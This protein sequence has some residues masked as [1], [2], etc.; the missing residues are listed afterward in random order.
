ML[1]TEIIKVDAE[2]TKVNISYC[3]PLWQRD[4]QIKRN[5]VKYPNR[6]Q[7]NYELN[8][9]P[10][11]V[12]C[13]G[14]SLNETWESIKKYKYIIS[15]SGSHKFL[16]EKGIVPTWHV[17]VDPRPH[18]IE[19][20]GEDIHPD[21]EF[22][23]SSCCHPK[24]LNHLE[25]HKAK[26]TLWHTYC[27]ENEYQVPLVFPK[28]EWVLT[29]GVNAGLRALVI[30]RFLGF[31]NIHVFGMDGN[32]PKPEENNLRHA[33][34]HPNVSKEYIIATLDGI[35]YYTTIGF[36]AA[37]RQ[38]FH[39]ISLLSDIKVL[40]Y[41]VGLVQHM[42]Y[43]RIKFKK[44]REEFSN[45][46][47]FCAPLTI[48]S[49]S[50]EENK[51][52]HEE[53]INYGT[54]GVKYI[55]E[56]LSLYS[57]IEAKSLLDYGCG[58]GVLSNY[59]PF[60]IWEYDPAI[61]GKNKPPRSAELVVNI[62]VLEH[63]EPDYLDATLMDLFR[64]TLKLCF[65]VIDLEPSKKNLSDGRNAHINQQTKEWWVEKLNKYFSVLSEELSQDPQ[66]TLKIKLIPRRTIPVIK[67]SSLLQTIE[68]LGRIEKAVEIGVRGGNNALAIL[69][70]KV[71]KL[72]LVDPYEPYKDEEEWL[73]QIKQDKYKKEML[74]KIEP[75]KSK[76]ETIFLSSKGASSFFKEKEL[77][78]V[79]I[80]ANHSYENVKEDIELWYP[81]VKLG[82][83]LAGHD[84]NEVIF[85][86]VFKAVTDFVTQNNLE[87]LQGNYD[88][89]WMIIKK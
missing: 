31:L 42:A 47:A 59:L 39:E 69:N 24:V 30:A 84:F 66:L 41:G 14:P 67:R 13:F 75:F 81:K 48:S 40:F 9:E 53:N 76:V 21:T 8:K 58:K 37:A 17:E 46:I 38:T 12:V 79:Y 86:G 62:N 70:E 19:L 60:P 25:K 52:L 32:F 83:T 4:E 44:T 43:K 28:G 50:I 27:G 6:I 29:G 35:D 49:K 1:E 71:N 51:K 88:S 80:D 23:M 72:Y 87:L 68:R 15:C 2:K 77:D 16:R 18:K 56:I 22:L 3:I 45:G 78:Y 73:D 26:I 89:D 11:A 63:V 10:I 54:S 74:E 57:E 55:G 33:K 85:P 34:Y 7:P 82:G 36:L 20:I 5:I 64:C 61:E 65:V